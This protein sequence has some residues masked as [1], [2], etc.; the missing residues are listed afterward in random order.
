MQVRIQLMR[1]AAPPVTHPSRSTLVTNEQTDVLVRYSPLV[2]QTPR[3]MCPR[4][5]L[6][7]EQLSVSLHQKPRRNNF[8][9]GERQE[10]GVKFFSQ[11]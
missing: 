6:L 8:S 10:L 4:E 7:A 11:Q 3:A 5:G 9:G 1:K 2:K